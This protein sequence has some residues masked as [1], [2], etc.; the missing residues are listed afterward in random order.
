MK[1]IYSL[2]FVTLFLFLGYSC[3]DGSL[4]HS[5]V[6]IPD[7]VPENLEDYGFVSEPTTTAVIKMKIGE[8]NKHQLIEGFGCAFCGWSHRIWNTVEREKVVEDLFSKSGLGLNIFRGEIFPSYSNPDT[9]EIEFKMDRNFMLPPDE[10]SMINNYWRSY[11]G[12][13]CGEQTQ[14]GQMW[15]VDLISRKYKHVDYFFSVWCPPVMWKSNGKLNGGSMKHEFY[16]DYAK[17]LIDFVEAYEKKFGINI[18]ALSGWNEPD[19]LAAMGGWATC[20]W[21][22]DQMAD[23]VLNYLRP[24]MINR[25]H[26]DM[27]LMYAENAQWAWAVKHVNK[28]L[29]DYPQLA[30]QNIMMAGHGYST[31]D[32]NIVPFEEALKHNIQI[33]QTEVSDDK[34]RKETW[35]DAM[36]WAKTFHYYLTKAN[37]SGFVWWTGA[38]PCSTT[39]ENLIQLKESLP[40]TEYYRVPRYYSYGQFTKFIEKN[41]IRVDV[42]TIPS[43][44]DKFPE[45]LYASAYVKDDTYT[46]VLVN[47]SLTESFSTLLEID[48]VEFQNMRTY[49]SSENVKWLHKKINPSLNGLRS[50]TV[51]KY[52]V[53]TVTGKM[54]SKSNGAE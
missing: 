29:Q 48:G 45:E 39:G 10:P 28:S 5:D 38:R 9:K 1:K 37:L 24:E 33:W 23:L 32:E 8:E 20:S 19:V 6:L 36:K 41:A 21:S 25:G 7:P 12:E 2:L 18:F 54:K 15:L 31:K 13:E 43:E 11:N 16:P 4:D 22:V 35:P 27:R 53:V 17:Y 47:S 50:I 44:T 42:E 51:P 30:D 26:G 52:S 49:T 40:S 34:D 46:I 3:D 14:L